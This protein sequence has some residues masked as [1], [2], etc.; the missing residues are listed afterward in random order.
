MGDEQ[1]VEAIHGK[2]R[3]LVRFAKNQATAF[4]VLLTHNGAPIFQS[5]AQTALPK[6]FVKFII[7]IGRNYAHANLGFVVDKARAQIFALVG[8]H[9]H[10]IAVGIAALNL[11]DLFT[12]NPGMT[13]ASGPFPLGGDKKF[14]K[15]TNI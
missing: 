5:I 11:G 9:V 7:G 10:Q 13:I 6:G 12:E 4:K 3:E 8:D 15:F 2:S 1:I 14:S